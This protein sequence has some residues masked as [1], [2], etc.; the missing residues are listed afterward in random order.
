[1]QVVGDTLSVPHVVAEFDAVLARHHERASTA[2]ER[3]AFYT[4][5][6]AA[7]GVVATGETRAYGNILIKKGVVQP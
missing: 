5:A 2:L 3:F 4:R 6:A 1:M 7:F